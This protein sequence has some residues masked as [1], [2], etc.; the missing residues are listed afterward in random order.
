MGSE[1]NLKILPTIAI[2]LALVIFLALLSFP[3]STLAAVSS[4]MSF[5]GKIVNKTNGTNLVPG[6]PACVS[7][8]ADTCDLRISIYSDSVGGTLLWQETHED[9]E[10]GDYDGVFSLSL[11]SICNSW[12]SPSGGC[13]GSGLVWG[14]DNTIYIQVEFDDDGNGDFSSPET[15]T[16]K[17]LTTV[18]FAY[19]A[20]TLGGISSTGFVHLSPASVQETGNVTSPLLFLNENGTGT[21]N[22][23]QFQV[24]GSDRFTISNGGDLTISGNANINAGGIYSNTTLTFNDTNTGDIAFSDGVYGSL[25]AGTNSILHALNAASGGGGGLWTINGN[26]TYLTSSGSDLSLSSTLVS[27]FSVKKSENRIRFG[28]GSTSNAKVEFYSSTGDT[29]M[30]EYI[31]DTLQWSGGAFRITDDTRLMLGTDDDIQVFYST[32]NN[33]LEYRDGTNLLMALTDA[34]STGNLIVS[35]TV[36]IGNAANN[37]LGISAASAA[38]NDLFWGDQRVCLQN[39][40]GCNSNFGLWE[41]VSFNSGNNTATVENDYDVII[42]NWTGDN[43]PLTNTN[44]ILDA[45][46]ADDLFVLDLL[47]VGNALY[48]ENG[49]YVGAGT[50]A[51]TDGFITQTGANLELSAGGSYLVYINDALQVAGGNASITGGNSLIVSGTTPGNI[52]IDNTTTGATANS[53]AVILRGNY[54]NVSDSEIDMRLLLN[55]VSDTDYRL[56]FY[57][58]AQANEVG[59]IDQSGNLQISGRLNLGTN[60]SDLLSVGTTG[61]SANGDLYWGEDLICMVSQP[62]CGIAF[63]GSSL[64]TDGGAI[65]YLTQTADNFA[66]GANNTLVA[67]FSVDV[68]ANLVRIG[69]GANDSNDPTIQFYASDATNSGSIVFLDSDTFEFAGADVYVSGGDLLIGSTTSTIAD[70]G[71]VLNGNDLF[72]AGDLGVEGNIYSDGNLYIQTDVNTASGDALIQFG[73]TSPQ[74]LAWR[75]S[76]NGFE[77]SNSLMPSTNESFNLGSNTRRFQELFLGPSTL[78]IGTSTTDEGAIGYNTSTNV[79]SIIS[80]GDLALQS[81]GGKVGIGGVTAPTAFLDIAA[82]TSSN[83]QINLSPGTNPSSPGSGDLWFNGTSLN[84]YDGSQT[85]DLLAG[86]GSLFTDS[87]TFTYL[88]STSDNFVLGA[89]ADTGPFFFQ[90]STGRLRLNTTGSAA[91]IEIGNDTYLYDGGTQLLVTSSNLQVDQQLRVI[92]TGSSGGLVI[93]NDTNLYDAGTNLLATDDNFRVGGD[94]TV[95]GTTPFNMIIDNSTTGSTANSGAL[96][97]RGNYY[98]AGDNEIDMRVLLSITSDTNYALSFVNDLSTEVARLDN[99]G[100]LQIDGRLNLGT[101]SSDVLSVGTTG[102]GANGDLYWGEDLL[103]DVSEANCGISFGGGSLFTDSGSISYLTQTTDDFAVGGSTLGAAF[104]VDVSDNT[105]RIGTGSTANAVLNMFASDGDTGAI[106]FTTDDRWEF[107][108]GDILLASDRSMFFGSN[109]DF[110]MRYDNATDQRFEFGF[111]A[112]QFGYINDVA[113]ETYG[114]FLFGGTTTLGTQLDGSETALYVNPASGFSGNL[115]ELAIDGTEIFT[116]SSVGITANVPATF[117]SIGDVQIANDIVFTNS[118]ASYIKSDSPLYIVA[119][120]LASDEDL[121]LRANNNGYVVVDDRLEVTEFIHLGSSNPNNFLSTAAQVNAATDNLYWGDKLVC[122]AS[123]PNCGFNPLLTDAGTV[124]YL[125][126]TTDNFAIGGTGLTAAFSVDVNNNLVRVGVGSGSNGKIDFY[127]ANGN[128]GRLEYTNADTL[129]LNDANFVFNQNGAAVDFIIEGDTDSY[130]INASGGT[131]RVGI[132]VQNPDAWLDIKAATTASAQI[133]LSSSSGVNPSAPVNGDLWWNGTNLY[134]Y[135]GSSNIDLLAGALWTNGTNGYFSNTEAIII[136]ADAAFSYVSTPS[137]GDMRVTDDLEVGDRV[138]VGGDLIVGASTSATSTIA[139]GS[140]S[141]SGDDM[142]VAGL[143]GVEGG[144]FTDGDL[145]LQT[146][147]DTTASGDIT[148]NFGGTNTETLKWNGTDSEFQLSDSITVSGNIVISGTSA[149]IVYANVAT[150][151]APTCDSSTVGTTIYNRDS[152]ENG[153]IYLCRQNSSNNYEWVDMTNGSGTPD[154]AEYVKTDDTSISA[155]DIVSVSNKQH[156]DENLYNR[157]LV[158]KATT[159]SRNNVL[160][161]IS[162]NPGLVLNPSTPDNKLDLA[163]FKPL[164]LAG[165][166]PVKISTES[167]DISIGDPISVSSNAGRGQKATSRGMIIGTA[168][169]AWTKESG[170]ISILV[171][172]N[173]TWFDPS[174]ENSIAIGSNGYGV[175]RFNPETGKFEFDADGDGIPEFVMGEDS[176]S[177]AFDPEI[178]APDQSEAPI[179]KPIDPIVINNTISVESTNEMFFAKE[180]ELVLPGQVVSYTDNPL[181]VSKSNNLNSNLI[182]G[183]ASVSPKVNIDKLVN[184]STASVPTLMRGSSIVYISEENG[185]IKRGDFLAPASIPGYVMRAT[186]PGMVVGRAL[187]DFD[188]TFFTAGDSELVRENIVNYKIEAYDYIDELIRQGL[189]N[190][191][192]QTLLNLVNNEL[193]KELNIEDEKARILAEMIQEEATVLPEIGRINAYVSPIYV[194]SEVFGERNNGISALQ[195]ESFTLA[196]GD[197]LFEII[198][199][200]GS[201]SLAISIDQLVVKGA[202]VVEGDLDVLGVFYA[203]EAVTNSL[204]IERKLSLGTGQNQAAGKAVISAGS[205]RVE[206]NNIQVNSDSI[207]QLTANQFVQYRVVNIKP[208]VGFTIEIENSIDTD[209]IFNYFIIN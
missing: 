39:G 146:D 179:I 205:V 139:H 175:I 19:E 36:N 189:S 78:H 46:N 152:G 207:V 44:F 203:N 85:V 116:V 135:N 177:L 45:A 209:T 11:N 158:E 66:V 148:I 133:N 13:S 193:Y 183:V 123:Q 127:S 5:Q 119:G 107:T 3:P 95:Q 53:G 42:G 195:I 37:V 103:C 8:G 61:A 105:V 54:F 25:P 73:G 94:L 79:L 47:G 6:S 82:S 191:D 169:E 120:D 190:E 192:A 117:T 182:A 174:D 111:G 34:G 181:E 178:E 166:V 106:T 68:A 60:T 58:S 56:S 17:L 159:S 200:P 160:G 208:G 140:F 52:V 64:F 151:N 168:L 194:G 136:G 204:L 156:E 121:I 65:T 206:V 149:G 115:L 98:N 9:V 141:L 132:G 4:Q 99:S 91:G 108:G 18:P 28:D 118:T 30:F 41:T 165:R 122:N 153:S 88:T 24:G 1:Q 12:E 114:D 172:I 163:Y 62:N 89:S 157:F 162:T 198:D 188:S 112:N 51:L 38:T 144:I 90:P 72:V 164:A 27:A 196:N 14:A 87:G 26:V 187:E 2:A 129:E 77:I 110:F 138:Y 145:Y 131:D 101:N 167:Q 134:F 59:S 155:G 97:L 173:N 197:N 7:A 137:A 84:F 102:I 83:A 93:G 75:S 67:P 71:F 29:G 96:I 124:T 150:G 69:D 10:L 48:V 109:A 130:L 16:R 76:L 80:T 185:P 32:S 184:G 57:N 161:I 20:Q 201:T 199:N 186:K 104:S 40:T 35:G 202:L 113:S 31:V 49:I 171:M 125:T 15:F 86:T 92:S 23:L 100:N 81:S 74:V 43:T 128:T 154:I 63:G 50:L 55:I 126:S 33:R 176:S 147:Q 170:K 143:L 142:F 21:P 22:L 70:S 180:E